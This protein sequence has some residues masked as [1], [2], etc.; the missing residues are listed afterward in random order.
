LQ[1]IC[2]IPIHGIVFQ[3]GKLRAVQAA[4]GFA[5]T[6]TLADLV[7]GYPM[8]GNEPFHPDFRGRNEPIG[9]GFP[10][11]AQ[12]RREIRGFK[13]FQAGFRDEVRSQ[14]R[15]IHL[16][17]PATV[18]KPPGLPYNPGPG[19]EQIPIHLCLLSCK[20]TYRL[21]PLAAPVKLV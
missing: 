19:P 2:I 21:L 10:R 6:E 7:Q 9:L 17:I 11:P 8:A 18:K 15:R 12:K 13:D 20:A 5:V 16:K 4:Q 1:G 3:Q 14:E